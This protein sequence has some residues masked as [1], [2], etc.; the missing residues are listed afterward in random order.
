M[1]LSLH[2]RTEEGHKSDGDKSTE[3]YH[4]D[5]HNSKLKHRTHT[6]YHDKRDQS[7]SI[8]NCTEPKDG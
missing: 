2:H 1:I 3:D 4:E 6:S 8:S 7:V 5:H